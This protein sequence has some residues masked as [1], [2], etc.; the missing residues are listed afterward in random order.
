MAKKSEIKHVNLISGS[1]SKGKTRK[2]RI[3]KSRTS[4]KGAAG[5]KSRVRGLARSTR[6]GR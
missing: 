2:S 4:K 1:I 3:S 5:T 6:R